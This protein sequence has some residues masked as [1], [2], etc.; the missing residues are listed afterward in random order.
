MIKQTWL[1][2]ETEY[3]NG[4]RQ[5]RKRRK[6]RPFEDDDLAD[7]DMMLGEEFPGQ[8]VRGMNLE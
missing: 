5:T 1:V 8:R 2:D 6:A 7:D 3:K 4:G